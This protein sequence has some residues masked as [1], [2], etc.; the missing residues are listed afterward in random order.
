MQL[1]GSWGCKARASRRER[2]PS[3]HLLPFLSQDTLRLTRPMYLSIRHSP[4]CGMARPQAL[5]TPGWGQ[6]GDLHMGLGEHAGTGPF[7]ESQPHS[8]HVP[9]ALSPH[10]ESSSESAPPCPLGPCLSSSLPPS[11][12][13]APALS[14]GPHR[15]LLGPEEHL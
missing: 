3:G 2:G 10:K 9:E 11:L 14:R 4:A 1:S 15:G 7:P 5:R 8:V 12:P 6:Q 13:G